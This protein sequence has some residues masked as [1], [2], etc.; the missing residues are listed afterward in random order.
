MFTPSFINLIDKIEKIRPITK[1]PVSPIK[2]DAGLKL[3][4]RNANKA[5]NR[6]KDN[7]AY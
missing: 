1:D 2:M 5:P 7:I 6:V 3:Y 4:F